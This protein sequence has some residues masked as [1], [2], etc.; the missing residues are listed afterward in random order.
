M[1]KRLFAFLTV[2]CLSVTLCSD[3]TF[4][5]M[6]DEAVEQATV[7]KSSDYLDVD[8]SVTENNPWSVETTNNIDLTWQQ[9]TSTDETRA[10]FALFP[11]M[12][13]GVTPTTGYISTGAYSAEGM[14]I[15][16]GVN[17]AVNGKYMIAGGA[18]T[19]N[20]EK[21]ASNAKIAKVF[22]VPKDGV[23][24][25][26]AAPTM[27]DGS[28]DRIIIRRALA[29]WE[30]ENRFYIEKNGVSLWAASGT[31]SEDESEYSFLTFDTQKI[32]VNKGEKL[33]FVFS[34]RSYASRS[35]QAVMWDPV[36]GYIADEPEPD[37]GSYLSS[38]YLDPSSYHAK[39]PWS[40]ESDNSLTY[41]WIE[42]TN[43]DAG[44]YSLKGFKFENGG[45]TD[46]TVAE[47]GFFGKQK[48]EGGGYIYGAHG[49]QGS[50]MP[51]HMV[52]FRVWCIDN[53][54]DFERSAWR[55]VAKV[56]TAPADGLVT[57]SA[58][59]V[60]DGFE[61]CIVTN[62]LLTDE[63]R[64]GGTV[65]VMLASLGASEPTEIWSADAARGANGYAERDG[66]GYIDFEPRKIAVNA[67]DKIYFV[68]K[69]RAWGNRTAGAV[70]WDPMV[71]YDLKE[72]ISLLGEYD[73]DMVR[74]RT[75]VP[76][77]SL[78]GVT[79][80]DVILVGS[81]AY[82]DYFEGGN[83]EIALKP[84]YLKPGT[85]YSV[86]V[87]NIDYNGSIIVGTV[88]F[89]TPEDDDL[90]YVSSEY[91]K[92]ENGAAAAD[93]PWSV[94]VNATGEWERFDD[95]VTPWENTV[96]KVG[97][98]ATGFENGGDNTIG[99]GT[100]AYE[101][102]YTKR[103]NV[104]SESQ[105]L[106]G[107]T[108]SG[109]Y[110]IPGRWARSN[111]DGVCPKVAK[112]FT[113]PEDGVVKIVSLNRLTGERGILTNGYVGE[114]AKDGAVCDVGIMQ[115]GKP[116]VESVWARQAASKK[117]SSTVIDDE[118][119]TTSLVFDDLYVSVKKGDKIYFQVYRNNDWFSWEPSG[120]AWDPWI[121]YTGKSVKIS[122]ESRDKAGMIYPTDHIF[123]LT[124]TNA[125][126]E[127]I[128]ASKIKIKDGSG[129]AKITGFE[130]KG[131][132]V[133]FSIDGL[134]ENCSYEILIENVAFA[135]KQDGDFYRSDIAFGFSTAGVL[136]L[137]S[138]IDVSGG[139]KEGD[140]TVEAR[141][142]CSGTNIPED[143]S[144]IMIAAVMNADESVA[145]VYTNTVPLTGRETV[146]NCSV[147]LLKG[148]FI[149][150][151]VAES[152]NNIKPLSDEIVDIR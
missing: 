107:M 72:D 35:S 102:E 57:L 151:W 130:Q 55:S 44:I 105:Q 42:E 71:T 90:C 147:Q 101:Y 51:K 137:G 136:S 119:K 67:G 19:N 148:Q 53:A 20:G 73:G 39:N 128:D 11:K 152:L 143:E 60:L 113:V 66:V 126:L 115:A 5:S 83:S 56:F 62:T 116:S 21:N 29:D 127:P 63:Y 129:K 96:E 134:A 133:T 8:R 140:N 22:T 100:V 121:I 30:K 93:N 89:D 117:T 38:E 150:A 86:A 46:T 50:V 95:L 69:G 37:D 144:V 122:E 112:A 82:V 108:V 15:K 25:I 36:V 17:A 84:F 10:D 64:D 54:A 74:I 24:E 79:K 149:R 28:G 2:F 52:P 114:N 40:A 109:A 3:V 125:P 76:E 1:K 145:C 78:A 123:E 68:L 132:Q 103:T 77:M 81:R 88:D 98:H 138:K 85:H 16:N 7:W 41:D 13:D 47:K 141:V 27:G 18:W 146:V 75:D 91:I 33:Y 92:P 80:S 49:Y 34:P 23:I 106:G 70:G 135:L 110:M 6:E 14:Y 45:D 97:T 99:S 131:T 120:V 9:V 61:G 104:I 43:K 118:N 111:G 26:N 124:L 142:I 4:A 58:E 94:E 31:S 12:P 139:L 48:G 59:S 65:K 87:K 32:W